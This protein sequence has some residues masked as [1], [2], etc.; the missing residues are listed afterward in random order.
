MNT[1]TAM[2]GAGCFWGVEAR[3]RQIEGVVATEVG[4]AGGHTKDPNY[5]DVCTGATG[6]A[7]VVRIEYNPEQVSYDDLLDVFWDCHN[8]TT[9]NRQG[10]DIGEQYRSVIFTYSPEQAQVAEASRDH[11]SSTGR[12]D[13]PI[14]TRIVPAAPFYPA[15]E[16][17]QQYYAKRGRDSCASTIRD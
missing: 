15:E 7:E 1:E 3:F 9:P 16:Y 2:F 8:P 10:L 13:R 4:F 11:L 5:K 17:H 14:V 6:H 12:Y